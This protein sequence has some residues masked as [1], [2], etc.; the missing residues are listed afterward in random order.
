[1]LVNKTR[2]LSIIVPVYQEENTIFEVLNILNALKISGYKKEIIVVDDASKDGSVK[3]VK[4]ASKQVPLKLVR[5]NNNMGKGSA[6]R[7]G[8][9]FATGD[10]V[11][12]QDADLEYDPHD[13]IPMLKEMEKSG[14]PVVYGSRRLKS[15]NTQYSG[16]SFY[17][18]GV[19]LTHITNLLYFSHITDEP[20]CYKMFK[21]SYLEGL[22]L[23]C[24]RFEFCP[25]VTAKTLRQGIKIPEVPISYHPR[26]IDEGKKIR[27]KDFLE[28]VYTLLRYRI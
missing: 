23:Q 7:T 13:F 14:S 26:H 2:H 28:A 16:L 1:M 24:R 17:I 27:S 9:R 3:R 11:V 8:L 20:T 6:I 25:E 5:H 4:Q 18:G 15:N 12:I 21:R 10:I 19:L 22:N